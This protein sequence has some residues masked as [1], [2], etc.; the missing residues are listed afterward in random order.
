MLF[1]LVLMRMSGFIFLNPIL[2]RRNIP[3]TAKTGLSLGLAVI[4]FSMEQSQGITVEAEAN[5]SLM[6][7]ILMVKELAIG[8]LLGFIMSLFDMVLTFAGTVIDF[9]IGISMAMVY[10]PQTG[11]HIALSGNIL[12]TFYLLFFFAVDGHLALIK[13]LA[14]SGDVVPYGEL[15]FTQGAAW[16]VLDI[17]AQCVVLAIKLAFPLI[18]FEFIMQVGVGILTKITPQINLFVLSIQLRLVVGFILLVFLV[19]P[20]SSF[21]G[22]LISDMMK[23]LQ[24]ALRVA[25]G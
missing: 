11:S 15:A 4:V 10:D 12:Q 19:S 20:I 25:A 13:I 5:S 22:D 8:Y 2:G 1:F 7:G 24:E 14:E 3:A 21:M 18:A 17:F 6:F 23:T 16:M 9:Q